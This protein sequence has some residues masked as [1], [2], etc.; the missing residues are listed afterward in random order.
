MWPHVQ[1]STCPHVCSAASTLCVFTAHLE[2][3]SAPVIPVHNTTS[4]RLEAAIFASHLLGLLTFEVQA[5]LLVGLSI[6]ILCPPTYSS[7]DFGRPCISSCRFLHVSE[8]PQLIKEVVEVCQEAIVVILCHS[9]Y[10][11]TV[12]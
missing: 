7:W 8:Q 1:V 3:L 9:L 4:C 12:V 11:Y 2:H 10:E 6:P 5:T